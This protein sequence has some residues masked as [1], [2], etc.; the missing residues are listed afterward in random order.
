VQSGK[1]EGYE[2]QIKDTRIYALSLDGDTMI[3]GISE[4]A[5]PA[6]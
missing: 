6:F 5:G 3:G 2:G 1:I 4:T